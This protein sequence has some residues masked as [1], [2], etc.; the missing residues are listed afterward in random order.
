MKLAIDSLRYPLANRVLSL[1]ILILF[2]ACSQALAQGSAPESGNVAE[3]QARIERARALAAA[4]QLTAAA[5]ELESLRTTVQDDSI[6]SVASVM[7]MSICLEEGNYARAESLLEETFKAR[8]TKKDSSIRTYFALAGQAINGARSHLTRYRN[9]GIN[10]S[11]T[12]LPQEA[13]KDLDRLRSL[14]ERMSFQAR[15]ISKSQPKTYESLALL[16]DILGIRLSLARDDEDRAKWETE[17]ANVRQGLIFT[18][19]QVASLGSVPP[20]TAVLE[21]ATRPGIQDN[22]TPVPP[23]ASST[24]SSKPTAVDNPKASDPN[25]ISTGSL[26]GRATR[27]VVPVYPQIAKSAAAEGI[28]RVYVTIDEQGNVSEIARS[29]GPSLLRGAAEDA[30]RRWKFSPTAVAGKPVRLSGFIE[31]NFTL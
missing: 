16:E 3:T 6:R 7:L 30:A 31:F 10:V 13:L 25:S 23:A 17:R 11:D 26:N 4:H 14:L 1:S 28:V 12:G 2:A 8:E 29:E 18:Q 20:V 15:E 19:S 22:S 5:A 27:R 21:N 9:F 24:E